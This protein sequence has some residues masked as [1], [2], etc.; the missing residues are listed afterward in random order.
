MTIREAFTDLINQRGWYVKLEIPEGTANST[1]KRFLE[2]KPVT[3][4]KMKEILQRAGYRIKQ[5]ELWEK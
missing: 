1:K 3:E 5:V 4:D 2:G